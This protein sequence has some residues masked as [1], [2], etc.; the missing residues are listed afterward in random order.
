MDLKKNNNS[1]LQ[2]YSENKN[3]KQQSNHKRHYNRII[4]KKNR[5]E[6]G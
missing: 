6:K 5:I 2:P 1:E 3:K 4:K